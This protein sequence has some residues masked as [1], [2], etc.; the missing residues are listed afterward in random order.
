MLSPGD[1]IGG[2]GRRIQAQI[3]NSAMPISLPP[4]SKADI[5]KDDNKGGATQ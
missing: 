4:D 3:R 2:N 1:L 5:T